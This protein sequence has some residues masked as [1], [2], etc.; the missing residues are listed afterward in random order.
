MVHTSGSSAVGQPAQTAQVAAASP[1]PRRLRTPSWLNLRLVAGVLLVLISVIVG[2]RIVTAADTSDMVW[3]AENDLAAGTVLADG[4]LRAV[5]VRLAEAGDAYLLSSTD[6]LGRVLNA[7]IRAGELLARS[8]LDETSTLVDIAL[9]VAAGYVPPNLRRGQLV[10]VYALDANPIASAPSVPET[11][12]TP[13]TDGGAAD[14]AGRESV[15][16]VVE[17]AVVQ[18]IA[19]RSDGALS[20]GSS[21]VQVVISVEADQAPALFASIA[22]RQLALAVRSSAASPTTEDPRPTRSSTPTAPDP[23]TPTPTG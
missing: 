9:P 1:T 8:V 16:V 23:T 15:A 21:T 10:D 22:G 11:P 3:A 4:D 7:P 18:L 20:V 14:S 12:E 2:A 5:A 6:P 17:A 13:G 19:G